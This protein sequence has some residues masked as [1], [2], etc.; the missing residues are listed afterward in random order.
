MHGSIVV[1]FILVL[2]IELPETLL[3]TSYLLC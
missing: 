2:R 1:L 3:G